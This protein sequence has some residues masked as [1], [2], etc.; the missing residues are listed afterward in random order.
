M[1]YRS[2]LSNQIASLSMSQYSNVTLIFT[3]LKL[4][5]EFK[6]HPIQA[7]NSISESF[8]SFLMLSTMQQSYK[9][10]LLSLFEEFAKKIK[11]CSF[12]KT[13]KYILNS[14][15]IF[16]RLHLNVSQISYWTLPCAWFNRWQRVWYLNK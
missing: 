11:K 8:V 14:S 9:H 7:L 2:R 16:S 13:F 4:F 12:D 1:R 3:T 15:Y 6:K 5:I 10:W